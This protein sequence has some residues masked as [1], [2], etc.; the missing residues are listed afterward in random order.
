MSPPRSPWAPL[1][2]CPQPACLSV[3]LSATCSLEMY[4]SICSEVFSVKTD[5]KIIYPWWHWENRPLSFSMLNL[6]VWV[7]L[8][9]W[10]F[11][12]ATSL[13]ESDVHLLHTN[14]SGQRGCMNDSLYYS[15][16]V[17]VFES[18]STITV[19]YRGDTNYRHGKKVKKWPNNVQ[20]D[21]NQLQITDS[22][23]LFL[24][25]EKYRLK[26]NLLCVCECV[27]F[28]ESF[29]QVWGLLFYF[30]YDWGSV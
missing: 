1:S 19:T 20:N 16:A 5:V 28:C 17:H 13:D 11:I 8:E 4:K 14:R 7:C 24:W 22:V 25:I 21:Q 30:H 12:C 6:G 9:V 10:L 29:K 18:H 3:C 2:V 15:T 26:D 23:Q 27:C